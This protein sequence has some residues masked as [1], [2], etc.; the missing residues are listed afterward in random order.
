MK[1][2][3]QFD[4][5]LDVDKAALAIATGDVQAFTGAQSLSVYY[6]EPLEVAYLVPLLAHVKSARE[7]M[8]SAPARK[9]LHLK[10]CMSPGRLCYS[11][12]LGK[13][14]IHLVQES[15]QVPYEVKVC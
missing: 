11:L 9:P 6:A 7:A 13:Q 8:I 1:I 14:A 3:L 2:V 5:E 15:P 12:I 10:P 4:G